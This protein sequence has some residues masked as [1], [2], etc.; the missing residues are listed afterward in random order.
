LFRLIQGAEIFSPLKTFP[1]EK[2]SG[3]PGK[4]FRYPGKDFRPTPEASFHHRLK[5]DSEETENET[6]LCAPLVFLFV[7][8]LFRSQ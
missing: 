3:H 5:G 8:V 1:P 6:E 4:D 7:F 2:I